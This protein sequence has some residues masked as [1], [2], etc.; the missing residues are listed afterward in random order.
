[1]FRNRFILKKR[2]CDYLD[3][4]DPSVIKKNASVRLAIIVAHI[5]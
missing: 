1:M 3:K 2:L 5:Y 4:I